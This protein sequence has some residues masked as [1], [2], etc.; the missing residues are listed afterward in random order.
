MENGNET[1][2]HGVEEKSKEAVST[3]ET[4][5]RGTEGFSNKQRLDEKELRYLLLLILFRS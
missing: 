3:F 4:L 1:A 2:E 5:R